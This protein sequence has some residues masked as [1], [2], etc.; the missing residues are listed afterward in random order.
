MPFAL[1]NAAL[2]ILGVSL[3]VP[4][5]FKIFTIAAGLLALSALLLFQNRIFLG[6]G[7]GGMER[8]VA[9]PQTIWL[10]IFGLYM[11]GDRFKTV[12]AKIMPSY[13]PSK[14]KAR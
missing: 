13:N 5:L 2:V 4:R 9:Y 8:V 6:L 12:A 7:E 11:T 3:P 14:T 1:G 10:I